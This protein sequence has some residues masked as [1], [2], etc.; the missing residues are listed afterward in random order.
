MGIE[1]FVVFLA[2][3]LIS[4]LILVNVNIGLS[5]LSLLLKI[6]GYP[7][8][9]VKT[10]LKVLI[11]G[12][13]VSGTLGTV[14]TVVLAGLWTPLLNIA[15]SA[16]YIPLIISLI[17]ISLRL[18]SIAGYWYTIDN[19]S[20]SSIF[21]GTLMVVGGLLIPFGFRYIFA[22]INYPVGL[23]SLEPL[24]ADQWKALYNPIFPPLYIH[25]I[26]MTLLIGLFAGGYLLSTINEIEVI[27]RLVRY[28]IPLITIH[29]FGGIWLFIT[30]D[31]YSPYITNKLLDVRLSNLSSISFLI[32]V[33]SISILILSIYL[34]QR[35]TSLRYFKIGFV[36][37]VISLVSG[38]VAY[39]Y[40]RFPYFV[41]TGSEGVKAKLFINRGVSINLFDVSIPF[42]IL[43]T[44]AIISIYTVYLLV[45]K[46]ILE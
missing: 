5:V 44:I 2:V 35:T 14:L 3:P 23:E 30:L 9:V 42:L 38:E 19:S 21:I 40:S 20:R 32:M 33:L 18:P 36:S 46:Y 29:V 4:H 1:I 39:D 34:Y 10:V 43:M 45:V 22:F 37:S 41:I 13:F 11:A 17:G 31:K 27:N 24:E 28:F 16:L 25:T 26:S 12:E 7:N 6:F 8:K 15:A